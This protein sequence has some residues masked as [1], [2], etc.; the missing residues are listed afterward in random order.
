MLDKSRAM[1]AAS[2][3][4]GAPIGADGLRMA[5]RRRL[6]WLDAREIPMVRHQLA[7]AART[8]LAPMAAVMT[9]LGNGWV[10][11]LL[12][13][14]LVVTEGWGATGML[15]RSGAAVLLAHCLYPACKHFIARPRPFVTY[16]DI[17]SRCEP[18]DYYSFPS[19]LCMTVCAAC[20]PIGVAHPATGLALVPFIAAL[21]WSRVVLGHHYPSDV[22]AGSLLGVVACLLVLMLPL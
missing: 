14:T 15:L 19:G 16:S 13:V 2:A 17:P 20:L 11:A 22:I 7:F 6:E 21:A 12:G 8:R 10:Y 4:I 5:P 9:V 1:Q 18:L 3:S